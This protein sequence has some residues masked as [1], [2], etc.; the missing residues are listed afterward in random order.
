MALDPRISKF[1]QNHPGDWQMTMGTARLSLPSSVLY[2]SIHDG[3]LTFGVNFIGGS[4]QSVHHDQLLE[5]LARW[6][7]RWMVERRGSLNT[8]PAWLVEP[9]RI[10]LRRRANELLTLSG[11]PTTSPDSSP[12]SQAIEEAR[13]VLRG[14]TDLNGEQALGVLEDLRRILGVTV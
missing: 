3:N 2:V 5:S 13:S 7:G 1:V 4:S 11:A 6:E 10:E 12:D 8:I 14:A 9:V